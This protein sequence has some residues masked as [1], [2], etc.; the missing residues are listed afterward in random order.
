M[1]RTDNKLKVNVKGSPISNDK[2]IKLLG[3]TVDNKLSFEP[4]L[5]LVCEKVS[6][7]LHALA[8][9]TKKKLRVIMKTF[10]MSQ[11]STVLWYGCDIAKH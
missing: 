3:V 4:H 1:L 6:Q 5:N 7:K 11:F 2:M 10:I 8:R 9:V